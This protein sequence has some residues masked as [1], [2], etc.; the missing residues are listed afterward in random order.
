M[1]ES[2]E[3]LNELLIQNQIQQS[4]VFLK[5]PGLN[6]SQSQKVDSSEQQQ[7]IQISPNT[8]TNCENNQQSDINRVAFWQELAKQ[9]NS[10]NHLASTSVGSYDFAISGAN[11]FLSPGTV[12]GS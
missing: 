7:K 10:H 11:F 12:G 6:N 8:H 1:E 9:P 4:E 2:P 5:K 3:I